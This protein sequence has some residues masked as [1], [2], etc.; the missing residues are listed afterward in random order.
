MRLL[1]LCIKVS[2][3]NFKLYQNSLRQ[4]VSLC[5]HLVVKN[6]LKFVC[7][8]SAVVLYSFAQLCLLNPVES[9]GYF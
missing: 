3:N 1:L 6:R 5:R 7:C 9:Q 2:I 8:V 4:K